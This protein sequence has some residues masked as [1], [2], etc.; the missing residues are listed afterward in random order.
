MLRH[1]VT[2]LRRT[3]PKPRWDWA[4]RVVLAALIRRLPTTLRTHR[5][6]TPGTVLR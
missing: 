4:D 6:V 2:V 1:E 3:Q 5:L